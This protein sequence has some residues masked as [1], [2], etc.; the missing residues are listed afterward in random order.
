MTGRPT[1]ALVTDLRD[2]D[3]MPYHVLGDKYAAAI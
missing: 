3:G 1:V 2:V